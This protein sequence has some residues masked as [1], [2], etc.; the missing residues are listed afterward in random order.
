MIQKLPFFFIII[1]IVL[2]C[3]FDK[4]NSNKLFSTLINLNEDVQSFTFS[5]DSIFQVIG[6]KGTIIKIDPKDLYSEAVEVL[7]SITVKLLELTQ[8]SEFIKYNVQTVSNGKWLIS[9]GSFQIELFSN[10]NLLRLKKG[11]VISVRFPKM[12]QEEMQLFYGER[13]KNGNM[14]WTTGNQKF[15]TK[16]Y[17]SFLI[18]KKTEI[19]EL[20]NDIYGLDSGYFIENYTV[21]SLGPISIKEYLRIIESK[22][23][24][25]TIFKTDSIIG[26]TRYFN[27]ESVD[28]NNL[29][30][31]IYLS[32]RKT[33][34][35]L[36]EEIYITKLGWINVDRFY[37]EN[38]NQFL[39]TLTNSSDVPISE[40]FVVDSS[41]NT[42]ISVSSSKKEK[43]SIELPANI[44][45]E[46]IAFG[47]NK[48]SIY[49]FRKPIRLS[50]NKSLIIKLKKIKKE[51]VSTFLN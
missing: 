22:K 32:E 37:P 6:N 27:K 47:I 8:P 1:M 18:N 50:D 17:S 38:E 45:F 13:K 14:N 9:G 51:K 43:Y 42:I 28:E 36:Y 24:D 40:L 33:Y 26:Y 5:K 19:D 7:G 34:N 30:R 25:T 20:K 21:D 15:V 48:E 10:G 4:N 11:K 31:E 12:Q 39:L 35:D 49:G 44:K 23:I 3:D 46:I 2:S 29:K 41:K 16:T